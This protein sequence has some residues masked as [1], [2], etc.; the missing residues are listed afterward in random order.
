MLKKTMFTESLRNYT[1]LQVAQKKQPEVI[2]AKPETSQ[3][4]EKRAKKVVRFQDQPEVK[5]QL[6]NC[7]FCDK[8][9]STANFLKNHI[10][11]VHRVIG[12][13]AGGRR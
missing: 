7:P 5:Q 2:P 3:N 1:Y 10:T 6:N 9:F 4:V 8:I 13:T 11:S 12:Q